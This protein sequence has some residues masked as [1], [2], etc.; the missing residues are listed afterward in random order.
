MINGNK[1]NYSTFDLSHT[2]KTSFDMGNL[3]PIACIPT[4]P[5]DKFSTDIGAFVRGQPTIA[6]ILDKVD[7]K[8]N[9][10]YVPYRVLWEKWE[11]FYM[12]DDMWKATDDPKPEVP[13]I[14]NKTVEAGYP[15][16]PLGRLGDYLGISKDWNPDQPYAHP[17]V[18][19][20]PFLAYNKI[21]LDWYAPQRWVNYLFDSGQTQHPL[22]QLKITL[23]QIKKGDGGIIFKNA[24]T[25]AL[26][27]LRNVGWNHDMFSNALPSPE[28]FDGSRVLI[29]N[30]EFHNSAQFIPHPTQP[31]MSVPFTDDQYGDH[32]RQILATV[33]DLRK[34]I[35]FQHYL[36]RLNDAGGRYMEGSE[37]F[38][39][40]EISNRTLQRS[41]Y[42]GGD[43][44]SLFTTEVEST[45]ETDQQ[46]LGAL[47]GKPV[48]GGKTNTEYMQCE[49]FGIFMVLAHVVPKRSYSDAM[50]KP[51]WFT[52]DVMDFPLPD[53]EGIGD[54]AIRRYEVHGFDATSSDG[55]FGY[56]ERFQHYKT[57][58]DRFSGDMRSSLLHWHLGETK[59]TL[60]P[61]QQISPGF[62]ECNPREDIFKVDEPQKM[63]GT[64]SINVKA[65]RKLQYNPQ[66]GMSR[67]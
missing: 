48:A 13:M 40:E 32:N 30:E 17:P 39:N 5:G 20:F 60:E 65:K 29:K 44:F 56:V 52:Q 67:V 10:F 24:N 11:E 53:F 63:L 51:L 12:Q 58:I 26:L 15:D 45:A 57:A 54:E 59:D 64:F 1:P 46:D 28:M 27:N 6:P 18:T 49:E 8:I 35:A 3:V 33:R 62:I 36:E 42:I 4:L 16:Y 38:W 47:A 25:D 23:N 50:S 41:E 66:Q 31:D 61:F 34:S 7:I 14:H 43:A 9:Q 37:V 22:A 21:Y 55:V 2:H 19:A